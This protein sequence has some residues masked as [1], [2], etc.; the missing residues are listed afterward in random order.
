M[1][2]TKSSA[3]DPIPTWMLK[4]VLSGILPYITYIVNESL[5][6]G[7]VPTVLKSAVIAPI[8]K[9]PSLDRNVLKNYRPVSNLPFIAKV[10]ERVAVKQ[11]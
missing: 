5:I 8:I 10:L 3:L 7:V 6:S 9:K 4:N 11:N 2:P 1:S